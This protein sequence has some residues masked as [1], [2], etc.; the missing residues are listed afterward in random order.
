MLDL[1]V[2][3]VKFSAELRDDF[4]GKHRCTVV[5]EVCW[6]RRCVEG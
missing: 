5:L 3:A 1:L 4:V 6:L 2:A